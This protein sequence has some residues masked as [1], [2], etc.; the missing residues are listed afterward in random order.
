[1][2]ER[3]RNASP[4]DIPE[5]DAELGLAN[6]R[7]VGQH[8]LEHR[9]QL[10][11]RAADDLEHLGGRRLLLQRLGQLARARLH[12]LEQ[13]R[14]LDGDDG[15][16]GEGLEQF[17]LA[18]RERSPAADASR[19]RPDSPCRQHGDASNAARSP[20]GRGTCTRGLRDIVHC[21]CS[22]ALQPDQYSHERAERISFAYLVNS[23]DVS[24]RCDLRICRRSRTIVSMVGFA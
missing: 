7:G 17:D 13:P 24:G 5:H 22:R 14:V 19:L 16:V 4:S 1:M 11:R 23:G 9:L 8:G 6:A 3:Q 10:A 20:A 12:L 18:V 15:L 2:R 21:D